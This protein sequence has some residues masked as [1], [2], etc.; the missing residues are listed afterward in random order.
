MMG[1]ACSR[2]A[3]DD[4]RACLLHQAGASSADQSTSANANET[5]ETPALLSEL[6]ARIQVDTS[7]NANETKETP[8]LLSEL[9]ARIQVDLADFQKQHT[10]MQDQVR[11]NYDDKLS[12]AKCLVLHAVKLQHEHEKTVMSGWSTAATISQQRQRITES[13]HA[14]ARALCSSESIEPASGRPPPT[15]FDGAEQ[16]A[17]IDWKA[18]RQLRR[19]FSIEDDEIINEPTPTPNRAPG[20]VVT[21]CYSAMPED[22]IMG[23]ASSSG[24]NDATAAVINNVISTTDN[25]NAETIP[26]ASKVSP[27]IDPNAHEMQKLHSA[28]RACVHPGEDETQVLLTLTPKDDHSASLPVRPPLPPGFYKNRRPAAL[29]IS[30]TPSCTKRKTITS[31]EAVIVSNTKMMQGLELSLGEIRD[32]VRQLHSKFEMTTS[33]F[34]AAKINTAVF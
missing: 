32:D 24:E 29:S 21:Q 18:V 22:E 20:C 13:L 1:G 9:C 26:C 14:L 31:L 10:L 28:R 2:P 16:P 27:T 3:I 34:K 23:N 25:K 11:E 5:K 7:A 33:H 4:T 15:L 6:C 30:G 17:N 19:K 12:R 8:A